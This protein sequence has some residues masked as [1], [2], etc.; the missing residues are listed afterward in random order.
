MIIKIAAQDCPEISE[1]SIGDRQSTPLFNQMTF[2][3][4]LRKLYS[5][6]IE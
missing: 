5:K 4:R 2:E 3:E 6:G 1:K